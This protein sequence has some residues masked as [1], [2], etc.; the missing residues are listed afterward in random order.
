MILFTAL[1]LF[2]EINS[3]RISIK[4]ETKK[5]NKHNKEHYKENG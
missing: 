1:V 2:N 4:D 5:N 3:E